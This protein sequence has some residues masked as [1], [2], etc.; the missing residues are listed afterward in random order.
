MTAELKNGGRRKP[1]LGSPTLVSTPSDIR[2]MRI[3]R[4]FK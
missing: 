4:I 3:K 1:F 2:H